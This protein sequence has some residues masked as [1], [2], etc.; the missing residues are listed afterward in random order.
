MALAQEWDHLVKQVRRLDGYKGFLRRPKLHQ[1]LPAAAEGPIALIN[2]SAGR[3]DALL[4]RVGGIE[5]VALP[6]LTWDMIADRGNSYLGVLRRVDRATREY[7]AARREVHGS[8]YE[9]V[10]RYTDAKRALTAAV[11][12]R[13]TMLPALL[14]WMWDAIAG[15]VLD[16][17]GLTSTPAPGQPWPRLWWCPTGPLTLLPL[18]A[19]GYHDDETP[20][21]RTVLD[22]VVSSYTP[23]LQALL[24]A[25]QPLPPAA[26]EERML[27]VSL[28]DTP[29]LA[30]LP[31]VLR[32]RQLL[33]SL[34]ADR[35][36]LLENASATSAAVL[37]YLPRHR[38]AHFSCHGGQ[39]LGD[40]SN[41][42]LLLHD[43]T[44]TI[45]DISRRQHDGEFA[46]LSACMTAVGGVR[47][48]D[49]AVTLVAALHY[50]GYRQ[51]IGTMWSVYDDAA[52]QVAELVYTELTAT[53][54]F[55]PSRAAHAL[56]KALL[57]LRDDKRAPASIWTPFVHTGP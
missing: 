10:R 35:H 33:T 3:C 28:P 48:P 29:G 41:G 24:K 56:H 54:R 5:P 34:F 20:A 43:R 21:G 6:G 8:N 55:V 13:D 39:D 23:T 38:W 49:E 25:R 27:I 7:H 16:A 45:A 37:D 36:T 18:H 12:E 57:H 2:V 32:E 14:R 47:L 42:G 1:L 26:D 9:T 50:T 51:V 15:P 52:A 22:R 46:F 40:P 30:P 44:V 17:L 4:V 31:D 53:G 19:A 11:A